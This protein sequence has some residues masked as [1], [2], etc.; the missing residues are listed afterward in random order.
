MFKSIHP[1][2]ARKF[3]D[4][5]QNT[6]EWLGHRAKKVTG[7]SFGTLLSKKDSLGYTG[8]IKRIAVETL[9]GEPVETE[10]YGNKTTERGSNLEPLAIIEYESLMFCE[11]NNGGFF[12]F[13]N[14]VGVSPDGH[15]HRGNEFIGV[16]AKCPEYKKFIEYLLNPELLVEDY[17][18]QVQGEIYGAGFDCVDLFAYY[19]G[20]KLVKVRVYPDEKFLFKLENEIELAKE[21]V[22]KLIETLKKHQIN[23][24]E[25]V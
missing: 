18:T 15:Y 14:F 17:Y 13:T 1:E 11:V 24:K 12:E 19:P 5:E 10:F 6:D 22:N 2:S 8:T 16:E 25:E 21:E 3:H 7:T 4:I 20:Y 23:Y 9:S